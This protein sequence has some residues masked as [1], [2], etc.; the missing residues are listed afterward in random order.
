MGV[1]GEGG[2]YHRKGR[3]GRLFFFWNE[4]MQKKRRALPWGYL[5]K[6]LVAAGTAGSCAG[7]GTRTRTHQKKI[8]KRSCGVGGAVKKRLGRQAAGRGPGYHRTR[9]REVKSASAPAGG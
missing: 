8:R 1:G 7:L 5:A 3:S 2:G 9:P 4:K 6:Y